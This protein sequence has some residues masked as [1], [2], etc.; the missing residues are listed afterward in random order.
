[1]AKSEQTIVNNGLI[2]RYLSNLMPPKTPKAITAPISKAK[3]EYT[4]Y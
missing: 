4:A 1:M 3:F 2:S